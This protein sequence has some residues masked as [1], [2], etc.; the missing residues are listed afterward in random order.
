MSELSHVGEAGDVRMVDVGDKPAS[1]RRAIARATVK[2]APETA[3]RLRELP[4]GDALELV[5]G[6]PDRLVNA[7]GE[8]GAKK[9]PRRAIPSNSMNSASPICV[10][11]RRIACPSI[12]AT[13]PR[14][15]RGANRGA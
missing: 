8:D 15:I 4:K 9:G 2:M 3:L 1:R 12:R 10:R 6:R 14:T 11:R 7:V 5:N 13:G